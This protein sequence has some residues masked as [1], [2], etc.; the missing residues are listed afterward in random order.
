MEDVLREPIMKGRAPILEI[1]SRACRLGM[2]TL[3]AI[4]FT[5]V[6]ERIIPLEE[7]IRV[8]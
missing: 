7:W 1:K 6:R 2:K 8:T 5:H 3:K 4:G